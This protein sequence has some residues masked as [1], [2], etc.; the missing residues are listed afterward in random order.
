MLLC[1]NYEIKGESIVGESP[2][3]HEETICYNDTIGRDAT[4][5]K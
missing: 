3:W 1:G 2:D 4:K 5:C